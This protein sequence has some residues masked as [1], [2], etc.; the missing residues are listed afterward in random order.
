M[1]DSGHGRCPSSRDG[2]PNLRRRATIGTPG[3]LHESGETVWHVL[4]SVSFGEFRRDTR[5]LKDRADH[6]AGRAVDL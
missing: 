2:I 6:A 3:R 4:F 1:G 5:A